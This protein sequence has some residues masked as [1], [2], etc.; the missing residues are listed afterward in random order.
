M[1]LRTFLAAGLGLGAAVL[2][3]PQAR[4]DSIDGS[5]CKDTG[6]RFS[7]SGPAIV[8]PA[9]TR[10]QGNYA[11]HYFSYVVPPGDPGAGTQ[12]DMRL[13]GEEAVEVKEGAAKPEVWQRCGPSVS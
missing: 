12:I 3:A 13:L 2:L 10:T 11:R 6:K 9:G 1:T 7:I 4:A 8:T 5:W